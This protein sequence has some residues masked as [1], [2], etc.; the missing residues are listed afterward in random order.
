MGK[1]GIS[2]ALMSVLLAS[3]AMAAGLTATG[4][5]KSM[6]SK[7]CIVTLNDKSVYQFPAKCDF[8]K[9]KPNEA[10]VITYVTKGKLNQ[11]SKIAAA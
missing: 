11:A 6:D 7:K 5:I 3:T 1:M 8:T 9:L 4:S 2:I 10:V